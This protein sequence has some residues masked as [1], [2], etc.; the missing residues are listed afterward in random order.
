MIVFFALNVGGDAAVNAG[1][2]GVALA[3]YLGT[4]GLLSQAAKQLQSFMDFS[5]AS[6][7]RSSAA[8]AG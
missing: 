7:S 6:Q 2:P 3:A 8:A 5:T 1:I 4:W